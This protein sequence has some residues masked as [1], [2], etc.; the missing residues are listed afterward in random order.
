MLK[1]FLENTEYSMMRLISFLTVIAGLIAAFAVLVMG[2][3]RYEDIYLH[4]FIYLSAALLGFGF[5]GKA[6]QKFAELN[7]TGKERATEQ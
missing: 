5:G 3:M 6:A 7:S 4:E 1:F 2:F